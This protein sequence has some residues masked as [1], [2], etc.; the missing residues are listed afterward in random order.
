MIHLTEEQ[1]NSITSSIEN[2]PPSTGTFQAQS[3][4]NFSI[5]EESE[6]FITEILQG[7][8]NQPDTVRDGYKYKKSESFSIGGGDL[9][10]GLNISYKMRRPPNRRVIVRPPE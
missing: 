6:K 4:C 10:I 3:A 2:Q 5:K 1:I 7:V 9:N 8:T